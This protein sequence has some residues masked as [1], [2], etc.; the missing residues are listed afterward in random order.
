MVKGRIVMKQRANLVGNQNPEYSRAVSLVA[1]TLS[2][3]W[4]QETDLLYNALPEKM[5]IVGFEHAIILKPSP[6]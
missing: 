6:I 3:V 4:M 1:H 5:V 2:D